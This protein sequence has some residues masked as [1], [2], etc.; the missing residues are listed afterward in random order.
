MPSLLKKLALSLFLP[1][2]AGG[3]ALAAAGKYSAETAKGNE[4]RLVF[5]EARQWQIAAD[6]ASVP[7]IGSLVEAAS[8]NITLVEPAGIAQGDLM[9]ACI[10]YRSNVP[11]TLPTGWALVATQQSSGDIDATNGIAS[12]VMAYIVRG[13]SAPSLV[14]TRTLG[15]VAQGRIIAYSGMSATPY[16]TGSANTLAVAAFDVTTAS[17]TTAEANELLVAMVS[18]GDDDTSTAFL[19]ATA[20]ATPSGATDTTTA[21]TVGTWIERADNTTLTGA[22]NGLAI[23]DAVKATAA[24]TGTIQATVADN[25][26]NVMIV[27]AFKNHPISVSGVVYTDEIS[28][29]YNCSVDNLTIGVSVNG[30]ATA[31]GACTLATGAFSITAANNPSAA[32]D[33][34]VVFIDSAEI[35]KGTT[36]TLALDA[37]SSITGLKIFQN[38]VIATSQ[39]ATAITNAKMATGDNSDVGIRYSVASGALTLETDMELHVFE[40]KTFTPGGSVTTQG[41]GGLH[42][43]YSAVTGAA[44]NF[45]AN[46]VSISGD[47]TIDANTTLTASSGSLTVGGNWT[48]NGTFTNNGGTVTFNGAVAQTLTGATTWNNLIINNTYAAP[49]DTYD[50][51]PGAVQ[52]VAG[53]LTVTDGQWTPY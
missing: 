37:T 26:R 41:G 36:V 27:G 48:N 35:P 34:V 18:V 3:F 21:P 4:P 28:T 22:D 1:V 8:G 17:I 19:A 46:A 47:V 13:A 44:A 49:D 16:D 33:P 38:R 50:V 11:F 30:G 6:A 7:K 14:F 42:L 29:P 23:A 5:E 20:P 12:G 40:G 45:E 10:G 31:T 24:A 53:T 52:T 9:V 51:D 39:S 15:D 25:S 43:A 2:L 32:G